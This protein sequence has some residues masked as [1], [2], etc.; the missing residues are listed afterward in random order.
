LNSFAARWTQHIKSPYQSEI[1]QYL[2]KEKSR[3]LGDFSDIKL[4]TV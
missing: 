3:S 2:H 1:M 4:E